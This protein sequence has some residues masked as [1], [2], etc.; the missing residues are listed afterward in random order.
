LLSAQNTDESGHAESLTARLFRQRWIIVACL[1][2]LVAAAL[3]FM[4]R[5][6]AAFIVATLGVVAWFWNERNR[7]QPPGIEADERFKD[8]DEAIEDQDEA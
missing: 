3:L 1:C 6:D 5:M 7:L 4:L 8:E 2:L